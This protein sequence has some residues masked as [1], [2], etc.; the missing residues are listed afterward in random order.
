[1]PDDARALRAKAR[2]SWPVARARV[3]DRG[4]DL[5]LDVP[6]AERIAMVW[7]LTLNAYAIRGEPIPAYK[8]SEA[9][10]RVVRAR[11]R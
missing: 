3:Q 9:P 11:D 10:G 5:L 7:E 8:R 2:K 1:M 4:S 6:V